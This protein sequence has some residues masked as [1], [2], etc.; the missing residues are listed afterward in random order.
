V[1]PRVRP[2]AAA[3]GGRRARRRL[4]RAGRA[5]ARR[6]APLRQR[7]PR[8]S[9]RRAPGALS[10]A[11]SSYLG[12]LMVAWGGLASGYVLSHASAIRRWERAVAPVIFAWGLAWWFGAGWHEIDRFVA[13]GSRISVLA[14]FLAATA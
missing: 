4:R 8:G 14:V 7:R 10:I 1:G 5:D 3:R 12:A 6:T 13:S 11:N 2:V 9:A